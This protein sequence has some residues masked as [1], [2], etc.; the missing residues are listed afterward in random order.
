MAD[1]QAAALTQLRNIQTRTGSSLADLHAAIVASGLA[2]VG[3]R[4]SWAMAHFGLGYG[5]ANT[6]ALTIGKPLPDLGAAPGSAAAAMPVP[7]GDPLDTLYAGPKEPLRALHEHIIAQV[8]KFGPYEQAPKKA[9]VSLR[10]KKQFALLGPSTRTQIEIGINHKGL[11]SH[12]RL[13]PMAPGGM[14]QYAVRVAKV[15]EVDADVLGWLRAA[16]DAAG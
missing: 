5:D 7:E 10:R 11:P 15:E 16:Y 3:E 1:P 8:D 4:R 12:P 6:L 2:K 9:T 14:C 13:R